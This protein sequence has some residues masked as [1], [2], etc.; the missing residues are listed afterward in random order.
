MPSPISSS[1]LSRAALV[2]TSGLALGLA[3]PKF[4]FGLLAWVAF[5]PLFYAIE[6]EGLRR[7]LGWS[8]LQGFASYVASLYWIPIPLH[9]FADVRME[10]AILPMMLLAGIVAIDTAVAIWAGEFVARRTRIPAVLAMPVAW[11]AVEWLRTYFP[12]GFPWNLLGYTAY[13][14]LELIQF[15]EFT[16]VYGISALIMFFNA[17]VYV[18]IFRRG[19]SRLQ[20]FSLSTLT[21]MMI[22]LVAFGAWRI[23]N[24]KSAP[25]I[26]TFKVAMVQGNI[27]QSLK[28]D[29]K[30]LPQSY[31]VYQD[32]TANAAKRGAD[33]IV[34]PEA[35]AAFIFQPDDQYPAILADDATYR[36]RLLTLAHDIGDPILFGA[37]ALAVR[38]GRVAG[39][40]NRAYLVSGKGEVEAHY[41]KMQLVPFGEYVPA[42]SILGFFVNR[43]VKGMGD[44]MPGD[45][46]TLFPVKGATLGVLI[47]YESIFPD[48]TRREVKLGANVLVNITNDAWYGE[49]SAPYQ[50]LAMAAMRSIETK[51]PMVRVANTGISA[52]I[53]PS[54]RITDRTPLFKRGTEIED[55]SWRPV[56][57][58]YTIVG[59]LFAEICFVLSIVG[60]L[61]AWR[62]P[63][64]ATADVI[65]VEK[66]SSN[67]ARRRRQAH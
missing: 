4:D 59:D 20:T 8:W 22:A 61:F 11:T 41:D 6:G 12:I 33:L 34:W 38:D 43:V 29:P 35:A 23:A 24:L 40:Y 26:G 64:A 21:A 36:T 60:L 46:P 10:L 53:E 49:S 56:R 7:V 9:D 18:V 58:G 5:V 39:F 48:L 3:F 51:V 28:W 62:W 1:N 45:Q 65:P 2:V 54:G 52:I 50:V 30:F 47:C 37:P 67:G 44:M 14:N 25:S 16:G 19:S 66:P 57:T 13:R 17:V 63:S 15:A 55:V 27:P 31:Q 42:R 32:E